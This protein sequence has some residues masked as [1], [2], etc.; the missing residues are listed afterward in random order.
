MLVP[1]RVFL[2]PSMPHDLISCGVPAASV[3]LMIVLFGEVLTLITGRS[4]KGTPLKSRF[5]VSMSGKSDCLK[6]RNRPSYG[7]TGS[8]HN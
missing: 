5:G 2:K 7:L 3:R 8:V 4:L 1:L 6:E